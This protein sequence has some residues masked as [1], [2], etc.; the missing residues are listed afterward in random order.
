[1]SEVRKFYPSTAFEDETGIP[2]SNFYDDTM[3]NRESFSER[4]ERK[5]RELPMRPIIEDPLNE[6]LRMIRKSE[7]VIMWVM[8]LVLI[9]AL[10]LF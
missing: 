10:C 3:R 6:R 2:Q 4:M 8:L 9:I 1:M 7:Y 5:R